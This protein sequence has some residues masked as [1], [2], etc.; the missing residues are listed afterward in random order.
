MQDANN[1]KDGDSCKWEEEISGACIKV[2][3]VKE[4]Q[5]GS[6]GSSN[7]ELLTQLGNSELKTQCGSYFYHADKGQGIRRS[8]H[9]DLLKEEFDRDNQEHVDINLDKTKGQEKEERE[10]KELK[11]TELL[12]SNGE[13]WGDVE[14]LKM[15]F[16]LDNILD[17]ESVYEWD[18]SDNSDNLVAA[19]YAQECKIKAHI[20]EGFVYLC[21]VKRGNDLMDETDFFMQHILWNK[22]GGWRIDKDYIV[23]RIEESIQMVKIKKSKEESEWKESV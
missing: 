20:P 11:D 16:N 4:E 13:D 14:T 12:E 17:V 7:I 1:E 15:R 6:T 19:E 18:D 8:H 9:L 5:K 22:G 3:N 21:Y 10:H 2:G 23:M